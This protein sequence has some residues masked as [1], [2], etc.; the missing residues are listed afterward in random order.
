MIGEVGSSGSAD[1]DGTTGSWTGCV[2]ED[3]A[4]DGSWRTSNSASA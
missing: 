3:E 1:G 4:E 2:R